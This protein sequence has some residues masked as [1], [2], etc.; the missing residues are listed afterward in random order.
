M[1]VRVEYLADPWVTLFR[2]TP[3]LALSRVRDLVRGRRKRPR[4]S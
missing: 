4:S 2:F 3:A 1:A